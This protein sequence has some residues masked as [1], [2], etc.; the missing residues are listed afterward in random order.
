MKKKY[1]NLVLISAACSFFFICFSD[2]M[3]ALIMSSENYIIESD[4]FS[5][6][7]G[8]WSSV[9]YIFR[10]TMG[11]VS[12]GRSDSTSYKLRAGYQEM[13]EVY[14][15]VSSPEDISLTPSIPGMTGGTGDGSVTW[16]VIIDGLAGFDMK[17]KA[18]TIPAMKL[19]AGYYFSDYSPSSEGIPDYNWSVDSNQAE[20]GFT[21]EPATAADT[22]QLFLDNNSNTCNQSEGGNNANTCWLGFNGTSYINAINRTT[23]TDVD[24][25]DEVF[26]FRAQS[27][28][29]FLKEGQYV[30][31]I[32]TVVASN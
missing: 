2:Q 31:T 19:D 24:G 12:T 20:F 15:A 16:R 13:L 22:V 23:R 27:N 5:I 29:K 25:E 10:D 8:D 30:A 3:S 1:L 26:K 17:I 28:A 6:S 11:E 4:D 7:G 32:T 21:V 14:I 9:N 18:S